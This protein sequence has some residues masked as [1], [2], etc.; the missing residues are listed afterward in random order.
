MAKSL[1]M[2]K[3]VCAGAKIHAGGDEKQKSPNR[4]LIEDFQ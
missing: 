2:V 3:Y 4:G 1:I